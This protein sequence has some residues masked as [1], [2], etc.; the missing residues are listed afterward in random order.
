MQAS[1]HSAHDSLL[2]DALLKIFL[3]FESLSF[4]LVLCV[5]CVDCM[6]IPDSEDM[7]GEEFRCDECRLKAGLP[8]NAFPLPRRDRRAEAAAAAAAK[9]AELQVKSRKTGRVRS[10]SQ[11]QREAMQNAPDA[12]VRSRAD[13]EKSQ[14]AA[15]ARAARRAADKAAG[16]SRQQSRQNRAA[17]RA[18]ERAQRKQDRALNKAKQ[19]KA[20]AAGG[21]K[22]LLASFDDSDTSSSDNSDDSSASSDASSSSASSTPPAKAGNVSKASP[23]K[24]PVRLSSLSKPTVT[25]TTIIAAAMKDIKKPISNNKSALQAMGWESTRGKVISSHT[26]TRATHAAVGFSSFMCSV[27][28]RCGARRSGVRRAGHR[29]AG[30]CAV[31]PLLPTW[32]YCML[33]SLHVSSRRLVFGGRK[34]G[35]CCLSAAPPC[36]LL[37]WLRSSLEQSSRRQCERAYTRQ[38]AAL[39]HKRAQHAEPARR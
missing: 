10:M 29:C 22:S 17:A 1:H 25:A 31:G 15:K 35:C 5:A 16:I 37:R 23:A 27:Y 38:L 13:I 7:A 33:R 21:L 11:R 28:R 34:G 24:P 32:A 26:Q 36:V 20:A 6:G 2:A 30:C 18:K 3:T 4:V 9:Q 39:E 19:E 8:M 12:P 14:A